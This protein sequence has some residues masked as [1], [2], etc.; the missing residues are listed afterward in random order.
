MIPVPGVGLAGG[1]RL[2]VDAKPGCG[3]VA[4]PAGEVLSR[5][6]AYRHS[7]DPSILAGRT[8]IELG[9]GTG[10]VGIAAALLEDTTDV[11]ITDQA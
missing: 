5:Y 11:W 6:I 8:V 10:L 4:W 1:V 2:K 7:L 3:G 9:S